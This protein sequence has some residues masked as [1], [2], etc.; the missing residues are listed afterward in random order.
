MSPTLLASVTALLSQADRPR[1]KALAFLIGGTISLGV[2]IVIVYSAIWALLQ[3]VESDAISYINVIDISLGALL[4]L[5]FVYLVVFR[6][7]SLFGRDKEQ[8]PEGAEKNEHLWHVAVVGSVLQG[9]DVS[10]V[11]LFI[12]CLQHIAASPVNVVTKLVVL[13]GTVAITTMPMWIPLVAHVTLPHSFIH[14]TEPAEVWLKRNSRNITIIVCLVFGIY[15]V[16]RGIFE[17]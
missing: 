1:A 14:R 13:A 9:R 12:A 11:V 8:Q 17:G 15:L 3:Q 7:K 5:V 2:W 4:L 6:P 16:I 10:S